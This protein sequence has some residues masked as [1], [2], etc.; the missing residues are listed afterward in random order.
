VIAPAPLFL[1]C[2]P[3][4]FLT[5]TAT[6][7]EGP[8]PRNALSDPSFSR[9]EARQRRKMLRRPGT[10]PPILKISNALKAFGLYSRNVAMQVYRRVTRT[11]NISCPRQSCSPS[12]PLQLDDVRQPHSA[13]MIGSE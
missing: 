4:W 6:S 9:N 10:P 7:A 2:K 5:A 13:A 11:G 8:L 12:Q 3:S 1:E